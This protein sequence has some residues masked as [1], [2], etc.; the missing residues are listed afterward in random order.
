MINLATK[1]KWNDKASK[2]LL[3]ATLP[4]NYSTQPIKCQVHVLRKA[5]KL[6]QVYVLCAWWLISETWSKNKRKRKENG[7]MHI[8]NDRKLRLLRTKITQNN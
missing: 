5:M 4:I 6:Q 1:K 3:Y 7:V 8:L 2:I